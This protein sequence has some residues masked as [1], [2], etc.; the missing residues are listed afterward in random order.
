[1]PKVSDM[2]EAIGTYKKQLKVETII[3]SENDPKPLNTKMKIAICQR[4]DKNTQVALEQFAEAYHTTLF[5]K[6]TKYST[7]AKIL[8]NMSQAYTDKGEQGLAMKSLKQAYA[9]LEKQLSK[10]DFE[11]SVLR[12][13]IKLR[14][15]RIYMSSSMRTP[16]NLK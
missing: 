2:A 16:D 1:M 13:K 7:H 11:K 8:F 5:K 10:K 4:D 3:Y 15:G 9:I 14:I 12:F 6:S